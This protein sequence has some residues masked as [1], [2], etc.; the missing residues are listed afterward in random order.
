MNILGISAFYHD[1]AACLVQDGQLVAAAQEERF[2]RKKHDF[3][4]PTNAIDYCLREAGI[5]MS[6]VAH[7]GY[8]AVPVEFERRRAA[9]GARRTPEVCVLDAD[10]VLAYRG[11]VDEQY[12]LGGARPDRGRETLREAL[13]A[14]VAG[15]SVP[16]PETDVDGCAITPRRA[17]RLASAPTWTEVGP[18]IAESCLPCHREGAEA[19]FPLVTWRDV[20]DRAEVVREAVVE[21]RMPPW[22]ASPDHGHFAN[23]RRLD[24]DR[25]AS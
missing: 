1:S 17:P 12:R 2:T 25:K 3:R 19:P 7:I 8:S 21:Q 10:Q 13:D 9:L 15:R 16:V 5:E 18:V 11:R 4:F 24:R 22:F 20:A 6:D 14:L 23:E